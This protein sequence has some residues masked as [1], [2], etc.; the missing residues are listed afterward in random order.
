MCVSLKQSPLPT[1]LGAGTTATQHTQ[2][3]EEVNELLISPSGRGSGSPEMVGMRKAESRA[4]AF[5]LCTG[6]PL[7]SAM[8]SPA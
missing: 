6:G 2:G 7:G 1:R 4:P 3:Q 5:C 8:Y